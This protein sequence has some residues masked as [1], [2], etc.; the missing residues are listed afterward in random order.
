MSEPDFLR[1]ERTFAAHLRN[2]DRVANRPEMIAHLMA[3][4]ARRTKAELLSGCEEHGIPAGPINDLAEV[5]DD[6]HVIAR[7]M[8]IDLDGVPGVRAPFR[9]SGADLA[10]TRPAPK[11]GEDNSA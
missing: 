6:P 8:R 9:F 3:E 1:V 7:G 5:F 10:L 4:T 11:L 2:P